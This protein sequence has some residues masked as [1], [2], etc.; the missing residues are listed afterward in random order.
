MIT[1]QDCRRGL[2]PEFAFSAGAGVTILGSS[3]AGVNIKVCARAN[4]NVKGP[5]KI[6]TMMLVVVK[7]NGINWDVFSD[8]RSHISQKCHTGSEYQVFHH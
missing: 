8:Q 6:S 4:Q 2:L 5:I 7:Q 1:E 3:R